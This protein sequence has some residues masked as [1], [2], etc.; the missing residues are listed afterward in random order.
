MIVSIERTLT[1]RPDWGGNFQLPEGEQITVTIRAP[2]VEERRRHVSA[3]VS[4][5]E[6]AAAAGTYRPRVEMRL[7]LTSL[8]RRHVTNITGLTVRDEMGRERQVDSAESLLQQPGLH[9]LEQ[10]IG[11]YIAGLVGRPEGVDLPLPARS[12]SG[13]EDSSTRRSNGDGSTLAP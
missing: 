1:Y 5:Q 13:V 11:T 10:E 4:L 9:D 2:T 7:D 8:I 6:D 3:D 12:A